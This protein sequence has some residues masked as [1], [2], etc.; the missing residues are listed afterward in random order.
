[1]DGI[2][3]YTLRWI[4]NQINSQSRHLHADD[5]SADVSRIAA[6]PHFSLKAKMLGG[7]TETIMREGGS[8][9]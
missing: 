3:K 5:R 6:V 7:H 2:F 9:R 1:M 4:S 8:T